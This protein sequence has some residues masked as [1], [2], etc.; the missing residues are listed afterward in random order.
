MYESVAVVPIRE[1]VPL[2]TTSNV[3]NDQASS[4]SSVNSN[5]PSVTIQPD[6]AVNKPA[7]KQYYD[8]LIIEKSGSEV[9]SKKNGSIVSPY[10]MVNW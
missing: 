10:E 2:G 5:C 3:D 4:L 8:H 9:D 7:K 6:I 1:I